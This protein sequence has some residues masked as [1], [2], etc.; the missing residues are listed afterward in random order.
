MRPSGR[1]KEVKRDEPISFPPF[2]H[3]RL[4]SSNHLHVS[5]LVL[6]EQLNIS[7]SFVLCFLLF[8]CFTTL[9]L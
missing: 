7:V 3:T 4:Q 5:F 8:I 6:S 2:N 9:C 1:G